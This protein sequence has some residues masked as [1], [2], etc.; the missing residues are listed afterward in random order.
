MSKLGLNAFAVNVAAEENGVW[1]AVGEMEFL[2]ARVGN[3]SW[4]AEHTILEKRAYGSLS[5]KKDKRSTEKDVKIM[6]ECLAKTSILDWKNVSLDGK[7]VKF[8]TKVCVDILT[9]KRFRPLAEHLL[10]L[11]M[12]EERFMEEEIAADIET[13]KN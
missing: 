8:S 7:D 9:D 4:K 1:I 13:I 2:V 11:A 6:L 3:D 10:E 12:D 5:R